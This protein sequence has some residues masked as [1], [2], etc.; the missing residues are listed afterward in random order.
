MTEEETNL[1][2]DTNGSN[3]SMTVAASVENILKEMAFWNLFALLVP[4]CFPLAF[5]VGD[6][7]P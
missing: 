6:T 2:N 1:S 5:T 4:S 7:P 3:S